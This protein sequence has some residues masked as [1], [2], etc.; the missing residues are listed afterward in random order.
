M[1]GGFWS[2]WSCYTVTLRIF[3]CKDDLEIIHRNTNCPAG[4]RMD[5]LSLVWKLYS[6]ASIAGCVMCILVFL[7]LFNNCTTVLIS[8]FHPV[9]HKQTQSF[10]WCTVS[11]SFFCLIPGTE[12]WPPGVCLKYVGGDQFGHVNMVMVRSL[13][14]QEIADV[15]VQMCSPSTAGMYQGQWRMCTATGLYYGGEWSLF[16]NFRLFFVVFPLQTKWML[17]APCRCSPDNRMVKV[18]VCQ[19]WD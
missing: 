4:L 10:S 1:L 16:R 18:E 5:Q 15:S 11:N 13:E 12:A 9:L 2:F 3:L 17:L 19:L 14:P 8:M 7:W 6:S